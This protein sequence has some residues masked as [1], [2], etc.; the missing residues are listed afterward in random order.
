MKNQQRRVRAVGIVDGAALEEEHPLFER[1]HLEVGVDDFPGDVGDAP[2][3]ELIADTDEHHAGGDMVGVE[4]GQPAGRV[5]A[6]GAPGHPNLVLIH[7]SDFDQVV[8]A[9]N[10]VAE[11]LAGGVFMV[12][13]GKRNA[14]AG[15]GAIVGIEDSEPARGG[16]LAER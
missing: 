1:F 5:A 16:H 10:D 4:S 8:N 9:V 12:H 13:L 15:A 11:L 3:G 2:F 6:V 7:Q 14:A